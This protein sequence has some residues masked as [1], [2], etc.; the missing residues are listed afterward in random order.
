MS[1][2]QVPIEQPDIF[3]KGGGK[4][5]RC[6]DTPSVA[7]SSAANE[8]SVPDASGPSSADASFDS[9]S[10]ICSEERKYYSRVEDQAV[11]GEASDD[12]GLTNFSEPA[13][14][15]AER[16]AYLRPNGSRACAEG[17]ESE[18]EEHDPDLDVPEESVP[19]APVAAAVDQTPSRVPSLV[20]HALFQA[21]FV[22]DAKLPWERSP[23]FSDAWMAPSLK[24]TGPLEQAEP[25]DKP[26]PSVTRCS[27]A[28]AIS[29]AVFARAITGKQDQTFLAERDSVRSKAVKAWAE[30]C[31]AVGPLCEPGS[32]FDSAD[33]ERSASEVE[34]CVLDCIGVRSPYTVRKRAYAMLQFRRWIELVEEFSGSAFELA[35][36]T[37]YISFLRESK[38]AG[39]TASSF[40]SSLR[41]A[42]HVLGFQI[43]QILVSRRIAGMS[44]QM[45]A[46]KEVYDPPPPLTVE[47]V[48]RL[49]DLLRSEGL[50]PYD[51]AAVAR[52]LFALY[53]RCRHSDLQFVK[54]L[55]VD[56]SGVEGYVTIFTGH[57]KSGRSAM[58]KSVLLPILIPAASADGKPWVNPAL[59][60]LEHAGMDLTGDI[61]GPLLK[62]AASAS[63]AA[64]RLR[65]VTSGELSVML[66]AFLGLPTKREEGGSRLPSSHSL[67]TTGLAWSA[68]FGLAPEIRA[69]LG[70]HAFATKSTQ[71]VYSRDLAVEPVRRFAEVIQQIAKGQ[72]LPDSLRSSYFA[73][74]PAPS[75]A[76]ISGDSLNS[77]E[78]LGPQVKDESAGNIGAHDAVVQVEASS[79]G[80]VSETTSESD[81]GGSDRER[82]RP[83]KRSHA[84]ASSESVIWYMHRGS[85]KLHMLRGQEDRMLL[86]RAFVCGRQW[87]DAYTR[88][89]LADMENA[90]CATCTRA[91]PAPQY[92]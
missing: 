88:A 62:A 70:R 36:V 5:A 54:R 38:V 75:G 19:V 12:A 9:W 90:K 30:V 40:M 6:M 85:K 66:R 43:D 8:V 28:Y 86:D 89:G 78:A 24:F 3:E 76:V 23:V 87:S 71:A 67:K 60:A 11:D 81:E 56:C 50:H 46:A 1:S 31:M 65:G 47:Q 69:T 63:S 91:P 48:L 80:S 14:P 4:T 44:E 57:H 59:E 33:A 73:F 37:N 21:G 79:D 84:E 68:K 83:S 42:R 51:R 49:H 39:Y 7:L 82:C 20:S 55:E 15:M 64:L 77:S 92:V 45:L 27:G 53:G 72:F 35:T 52:I 58:Q 10:L 16:A 29:T 2:A 25:A 32:L 26:K 34:R 41:F 61:S 18:A 22:G 13:E 17:M 74:P